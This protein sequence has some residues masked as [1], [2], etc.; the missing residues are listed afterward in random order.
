VYFFAQDSRH[1]TA[2][3]PRAAAGV[4]ARCTTMERATNTMSATYHPRSAIH[5]RA[6]IQD[7]VWRNSLLI[8][9]ISHAGMRHAHRHAHHG[10][11]KTFGLARHAMVDYVRLRCMLPIGHMRGYAAEGRISKAIGTA[12][13]PLCTTALHDTHELLA[14]QGCAR[15]GNSDAIEVRLRLSLLW[16]WR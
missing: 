8:P 15:P 10:S 9:L 16:R 3:P 11:S 6:G 14:P 1:M 2:Q 7:V 12:F 5:H 4:C 13:S